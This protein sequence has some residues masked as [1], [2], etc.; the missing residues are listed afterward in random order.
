[1][2]TCVLCTTEIKHVCDKKTGCHP[3]TGKPQCEKPSRRF[4][5]RIPSHAT[6]FYKGLIKSALLSSLRCLVV[7]LVSPQTRLELTVVLVS[8]YM[9]FLLSVT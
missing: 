7:Y 8:E 1:M 9:K 4:C 3:G 2:I 6:V 5:G